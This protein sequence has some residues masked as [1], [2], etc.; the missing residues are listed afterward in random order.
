MSE[1]VK[2]TATVDKKEKGVGFGKLMAWSLRGGSTGVALMV[3]GYLSIFAIK[4]LG[5]PAAT[6]ERK[7]L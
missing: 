2:S 5:I 3:M 1:E 4:I 7:R 6:V